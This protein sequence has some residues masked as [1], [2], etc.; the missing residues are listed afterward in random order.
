MEQEREGLVQ[1]V[2]VKYGGSVHRASYFVEHSIIHAQVSGHLMLSPRGNISAA[3][4][5][6]A[7]LTG[8]LFQQR[9]V[10]NQ[11]KRWLSSRWLTRTVPG[12]RA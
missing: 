1:T 8:R 10:A 12:S 6:K 2:E 4:T 5:V 11:A 3:D 7:L 9:R